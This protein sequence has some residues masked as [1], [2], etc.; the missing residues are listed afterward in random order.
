MAT[1]DEL[2]NG[3]AEVDRTLV[4][5]NGFRTI[6]IPATVPVLG[7]AT[8]DDVLR[9]DF[10]MPRY[11][12]DTDLS[13]YSI[14]VNYINANG[15]SDAYT[16]KDAVVG[17]QYITFTWLV[18]PIATQYKGDTKFN[19]SLTKLTSDNLYVDSKF[20]T[21][22]AT[23]PVLEGLEVDESIVTQYSD[24]IEQWRRELFGIGDT[25]E[26]SIR[27]ASQ[28]EQ[29]AI[30][31]KGAEV[32]ATIP[33][34]YQT[35][36]NM[37]DNAERTKADAIVCSTQGEKITVSDSSDD[38]LR[39][40]KLFG[41]STQ[42]RT[43]GTQL[44]NPYATQNNS[45]GNAVVE[46][47]GARITVTGTYYVSWPLVLKA[48][49]TYYINFKTVGNATNRAIRFE[50][51]DKEITGTV[52]NPASFTP[53]KDT[54]S[55]Y[56]Y[57]GLGTEGTIIY[58]DVQISE[59]TSAIPWEP[60]SGG[61]VS[62]SP[63]WPQ[64]IENVEKPTVDIYG[65]NFWPI[66]H[67][68]LNGSSVVE[69]MFVGRLPLP[70]TLSWT[71]DF[72]MTVGSAMFSYVIDG[73]TYYTSTKTTP[74]RFVLV[75]N[76]TG[77]LEKVTLL[78]WAPE[79]GNLTDIQLEL[80]DKATD[81]EPYRTKQTVA[82]NNDLLGVP[83]ESDGNYTDANGKKWICDEIDFERG[84]YIKRIGSIIFDGSEDEIWY[85]ELVL[86]NT[87]M[88]RIQIN[89][90]VNIGNVVG[91]DY[92]CS[93]FPV[94]NMYNSDVEGTQHTMQQFYFRLK[95]ATLSTADMDGFRAYLDEKPMTVQY[96]LAKPLETPLTAEE[97]QWFRFAHTN[98]PN[99][100][101]LNDAGTTMELK[102]NAD[103]KTWLENL[104]KTTI[105]DS[106]TLKDQSTGKKYIVY[107]NNGKLM[108][109]E[110]EV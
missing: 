97:I 51:P 90:S 68:V 67:I 55:V 41:K 61:V 34:D 110:S 100:T 52:T 95:K 76:K 36:V 21:T 85:D 82:T 11:V 79:T 3:V 73:T 38:Y 12:S 106:V 28:S 23:L 70:A 27:A 10:R 59:G 80:G 71:Q 32:L 86:D 13:T 57:S 84:V 2:L 60:Y 18:G 101:V 74:G 104:P 22:P 6:K 78:N 56:L 37:V 81:Y 1:A 49:V 54:V 108:M 92:I 72:A 96:V 87:V 4:I 91:K 98:Y 17:S 39:E 105:G 29:E 63:S 53:T 44:F 33:A 77:V 42:V 62:P 40:L 93:N 64:E 16:V 45:F 5:D 30:A 83:V 88:F 109:K 8:D 65:K 46:N 94:K 43:T 15:D 24:I 107:V 48:G 47:N 7:V 103:T 99:T 35:A 26:A 75:I 19:V 102:Y 20:N 89:D 66:G 31:N 69:N 58:E 9:L 25:E 50:Y 14:R